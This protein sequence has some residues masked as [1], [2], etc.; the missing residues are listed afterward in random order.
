[1]GVRNLLIG[2]GSGTG[3]TTVCDELERR[4]YQVVHGDRALAYQGDPET[5]EPTSGRTP[6]HH[7]WDVAKVKALVA[8][9]DEPVTV[10]C[11]APGTARSPSTSWLTRPT[12]AEGRR[13][14]T[15]SCGCTTARKAFRQGRHSTP[16]R[17]CNASSTR[18]FVASTRTPAGD[19]PGA[20]RPPSSLAFAGW[21]ILD[22]NQGP[23]P[24]QRSALT[25]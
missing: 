20:V 25:D 12:G 23:L 17:R 11:G 4:G 21:A 19:A 14:D 18:S 5:G 1:M 2:G 10:F 16:P 15:A 6:E 24:Y 3:E 8:N 22:S 13:T 9:Q 7:I